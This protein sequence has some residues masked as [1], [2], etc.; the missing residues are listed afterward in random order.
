MVDS[1]IGRARKGLKHNMI[2][3]NTY[4][5]FMVEERNLR[6]KI[7]R[8]CPSACARMGFI[9]SIAVSVA[10]LEV[11]L[12]EPAMGQFPI[13]SLSTKILIL[14]NDPHMLCMVSGGLMLQPSQPSIATKS[15]CESSMAV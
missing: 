2:F 5:V 7:L 11:V 4:E 3:S 12:V 1:T 6:T 14:R 9:E 15:R 13:E 8:L 10:D